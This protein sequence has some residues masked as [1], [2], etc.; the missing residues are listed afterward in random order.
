MHPLSHGEAE[1]IAMLIEKRMTQMPG[2]D[3]GSAAAGPGREARGDA[4]RS[5]FEMAV[6]KD[7]D[8]VENATMHVEKVMMD[9]RLQGKAERLVKRGFLHVSHSVNVLVRCVGA[10]FGRTARDAASCAGPAAFR[11][12]EL[13]SFAHVLVA[14][15]EADVHCFGTGAR[16][17]CS[18]S[19]IFR[20]LQ[21]SEQVVS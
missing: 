6:G 7:F 18:Y 11:M 2:A 15:R 5:S 16:T 19:A 20:S 4:F 9:P 1:K 3:D 21:A 10:V 12:L 13:A 14:L 8:K 17:S